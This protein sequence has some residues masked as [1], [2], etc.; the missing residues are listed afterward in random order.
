M[1][2]LDF[3]FPNTFGP[4]VIEHLESVLVC[5]GLQ[6]VCLVSFMFASSCTFWLCNLLTFFLYKSS[7]LCVFLA[8]RG[9]FPS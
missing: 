4:Q 8:L 2:I 9:K 5:G 7:L 3:F 6:K 1:F